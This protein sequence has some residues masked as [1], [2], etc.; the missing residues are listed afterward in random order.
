MT[1]MTPLPNFRYPADSAEVRYF[2][3]A[4]YQRSTTDMLNTGNKN[5]D[6]HDDS[7]K[8]FSIRV[9]AKEMR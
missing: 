4:A 8:T 9:Y 6:A 3:F 7:S 1:F 2:S 5:R